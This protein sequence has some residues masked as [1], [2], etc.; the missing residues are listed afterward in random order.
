MASAGFD[1][2][3]LPE[4]TVF[5]NQS[6]LQTHRTCSWKAHCAYDLNLVKDTKPSLPLV[7]GTA[8]HKMVEGLYT[9]GFG[10]AEALAEKAASEIMFAADGPGSG[11]DI[12]SDEWKKWDD[13]ATWIETVGPRYAIVWGEQHWKDILDVERQGWMWFDQNDVAMIDSDLKLVSAMETLKIPGICFMLTPDMIA[14]DHEDRLVVVDAK[15]TSQHRPGFVDMQK[16]GWQLGLYVAWANFMQELYG[17]EIDEMNAAML[18]VT[19]TT[20]LPKHPVKIAKNGNKINEKVYA[21]RLDNYHKK[22]ETFDKDTFYR[23][24]VPVT[25]ERQGQVLYE[26]IN[27]TLK[28]EAERRGVRRVLQRVGPACTAWGRQCQY[29]KNSCLLNADPPDT[30]PARHIDYVDKMEG[31]RDAG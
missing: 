25:R 19:S 24:T 7:C 12:G 26:M 18:D 16:M 1:R 29:L 21:T 14:V 23:E 6:R 28:W 2:P 9:K 5:F 13:R 10:Q 17:A 11:I 27:E 8:W 20:G 4:G 30:W 22:L 3:I 31:K 15:T